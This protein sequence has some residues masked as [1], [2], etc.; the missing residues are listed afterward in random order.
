MTNQP[1][2]HQVAQNYLAQ[3]KQNLAR[4]IPPA[5]AALIYWKSQ[6][7]I[8]GIQ[9]IAPEYSREIV[10]LSKSSDSIP[11]GLRKAIAELDRGRL[12]LSVEPTLD[13]EGR[14]HVLRRVGDMLQQ[15]TADQLDYVK[16]HQIA[17]IEENTGDIVTPAQPK[18]YISPE[19]MGPSRN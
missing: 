14:L 5:T 7:Y 9:E 8:G 15:M 1:N 12:S 3:E 19:A 11:E 4:N 16:G 6:P 2:W 13:L 18:L 10:L 17:I